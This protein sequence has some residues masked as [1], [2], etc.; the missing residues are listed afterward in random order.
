MPLATINGREIYYE[1]HGEGEEWITLLNG[2]TMNTAGWMLQVPDFAKHFRVL[3]LDF[4][5]QGKSAMPQEASYPLERQSDDLAALLDHLGIARTHVLGISYGGV[6]AQQFVLRHRARVNKL[7]LVDT[8]ACSDAVTAALWE[9]L[10]QAQAAGGHHLRFVTMLPMAFGS[11]FLEIAA[12]MI[13]AM[14]AS[15]SQVPW[16]AVTALSEA[17]RGLDMR[18]HYPGFNVETLVMVGDEDRFTPPY[19][20]R[21]I[22]NGIPGAKLRILPGVGHASTFENPPLVNQ[23]AL[24]FLL[25]TM[26]D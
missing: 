1:Q 23:T 20:A 22:A 14:E 12:K 26:T 15:E 13:P 24:S 7:V 17:L 25:G 10:V 3:L 6:V 11:R 8:L 5:G 9:S 4:C 21:M 19:Q 16:H 18:P 2:V